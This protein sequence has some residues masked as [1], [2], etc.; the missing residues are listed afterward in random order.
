MVPLSRMYL[1]VHSANQVLFGLVLGQI[2][3]ILYKYI[4]QRYI[5]YL[6]WSVLMKHQKKKKLI[7]AIIIHILAWIIPIIFFKINVKTRPVP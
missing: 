5:Y 3:L 1:G 4:Y 7:I 6:F 2:F